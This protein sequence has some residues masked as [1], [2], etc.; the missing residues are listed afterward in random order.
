MQSPNLPADM[1]FMTQ[2]IMDMQLQLMQ[3]QLTPN[4]YKATSTTNPSSTF[5]MPPRHGSKQIAI[6]HPQWGQK[7]SYW[8]SEEPSTPT[9]P[10]RRRSPKNSTLV[11][12]SILMTGVPKRRHPL[13]HPTAIRPRTECRLRLRHRYW[14]WDWHNR[15]R[16]GY[17]CGFE[18]GRRQWWRDEDMIL[19]IS[20]S[21]SPLIS[22]LWIR[23]SRSA[24]TGHRRWSNDG[25]QRRRRHF[26][27]RP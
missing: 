3:L 9:S 26:H 1:Q 10:T 2:S 12:T 4:R 27:R 18:C 13:L 14:L 20:P 16:C 23:P 22:I 15:R 21:S 17:G 24:A 6:L 7:S 8:Q 19:V 25:D 5:Q 11:W